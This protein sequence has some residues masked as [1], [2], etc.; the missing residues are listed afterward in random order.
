MWGF[1]MR[2]LSKGLFVRAGLLIVIVALGV[3][4]LQGNVATSVVWGADRALQLPIIFGIGIVLVAIAYFLKKSDNLGTEGAIL[5]TVILGML[6]RAGYVLMYDIYTLQNDVG[7]FTGFGT[8]NINNGHIGYAEYIYKFMKLPDFDPYSLFP[9][10][11]PPVHYVI[12]ALWL[13]LQ[14]FIGVPEVL[15]FENLQIPT[16]I[17]SGLCILAMVHILDEMGI[18]ERGI[19]IGSVIMAFHPKLIVLAGSVNNDALSLLLILVTIW[20][21]LTWIGDKT[22]LNVILAALSLGLGMIVKLNT[23]ITAFSIGIIF[24]VNLVAV[25]RDG[26]RVE[27]RDTFLQY[28]VFAVVSIPI[29]LSFVIRNIVVFDKLPGIPTM[30]PDSPMYTGAASVWARFGIPSLSALHFEFPFHGVNASWASNT[31]VIMFQTRMFSESFPASI[32]PGVLTMA[33][34][35]YGAS[36]VAGV[37]LAV[38][39]V[40]GCLARILAD[41]REKE[42]CIGNLFLLLTFLFVMG[43]YALFVFKYPY[44][45]SSDYRYITVELAFLSIGFVWTMREKKSLLGKVLRG[46]TGMSVAVMLLGSMA[47]Y[48][49]CSLS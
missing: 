10:F 31:W 41:L 28:I 46:I 43:S 7:S 36:I 20:R 35:A 27:L 26:N 40:V 2:N 6:V 39:F 48:M 23:M 16:L 3:A 34:I 14:R 11:H 38:A 17:Y 32:D 29:G 8:D 1:G 4:I 5:L 44:T 49:F 12:E 9:Y 25:I 30:T 24:L 37:I 15:A 19:V 21:V 22:Y 45:C 13:T 33:Q 18:G 47:F 42:E